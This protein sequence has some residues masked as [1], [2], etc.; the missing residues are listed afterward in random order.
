M[1]ALR[2]VVDGM[3]ARL[4]TFL[5]AVLLGY[6]IHADHVNLLVPAILVIVGVGIDI[7]ITHVT[8]KTKR[9]LR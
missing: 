2:P 5:G 8:R 3:L 1:N 7:L 9:P 4:G 6:G